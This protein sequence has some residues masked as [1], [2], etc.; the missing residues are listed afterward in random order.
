MEFMGFHLEAMICNITSSIDLSNCKVTSQLLRSRS[1]VP[2]GAA[3]TK[4]IS[5]L[6]REVLYMG[7]Y[8][9][10]YVQVDLSSGTT[11]CATTVYQSWPRTSQPDRSRH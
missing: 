11:R 6:H 10:V 1:R 7:S 9:K 4:Q 5:L 3:G 2:A 8:Y